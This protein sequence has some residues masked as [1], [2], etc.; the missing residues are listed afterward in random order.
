MNS[1]LTQTLTTSQITNKSA[2]LYE[3]LMWDVLKKKKKEK[4]SLQKVNWGT[5]G[6]SR[7]T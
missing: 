2:E 6:V 7:D 3:L 5:Y 1:S 4:K